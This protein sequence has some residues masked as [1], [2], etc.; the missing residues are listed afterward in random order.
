MVRLTGNELTGPS[1]NAS[2]ETPGVSNG[3]TDLGVFSTRR[4]ALEAYEDW[5]RNQPDQRAARKLRR[6][7]LRAED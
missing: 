2:V 7:I 6:H 1:Y 3:V 5:L 4:E